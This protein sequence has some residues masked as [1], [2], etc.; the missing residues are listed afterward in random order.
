MTEANQID[1]LP[2]VPISAFKVNPSA[3]LTTGAVVTNHGRPRAAFVP[4]EGAP[5][6]RR[7]LDEVKA[8]LLMLTRMT[9]PDEA[10]SELAALSA[11]RAADILGD[12]R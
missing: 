4:I 11:S 9:D 6:A 8:Q 7:S 2:R 3:Y 10:A 5:R 12:A 1:D